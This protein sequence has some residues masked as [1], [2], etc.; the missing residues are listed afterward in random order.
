MQAAISALADSLS[1]Y[2]KDE[3][4]AACCR[5]GRIVLDA[6]EAA[7]FKRKVVRPDALEL[8]DLT[9]G[10]EHLRT[11]RCSIYSDR[12]QVCRDFPLFLRHKT[13]F[14]STTCLA[15][16]AGVLDEGLVTLKKDHPSLHIIRQ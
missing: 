12:P 3:C 9:S 13:L 2:C 11:D 7:F 4:H 15:V 10:C 1:S 6:S 14:V 16:D 5:R 8:V